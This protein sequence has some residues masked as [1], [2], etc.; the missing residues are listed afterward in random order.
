[1]SSFVSH[2]PA[3]VEHGVCALCGKE[4][5][6]CAVVRVRG[7]Q[8]KYFRCSGCRIRTSDWEAVDKMTDF[9]FGIK[10]EQKG[11]DDE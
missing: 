4:S 5:A 2:I 1:M 3:S 9:Y 8:S 7:R 10:K 6:L 11:A